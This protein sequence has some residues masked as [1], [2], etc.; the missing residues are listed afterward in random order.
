MNPRL[1]LTGVAVGAL[2]LTGCATD[3]GGGSGGGSDSLSLGYFMPETGPSASYGPPMIAAVK[4]A[5]DEI[6]ADGGVLG[7]DVEVTGG[8]TAG[9][10]T[11][12]S[13]TIDRL[14]SENV[15]A[16]FGS[17]S[18]SITLA[19]LDKLASSGTMMCSGSDSATELATYPDDGLYFRTYPAATLLV[20]GVADWMI[21]DGATDIALVGRSDAI[22]K[23][24]VGGL[25]AALEEQGVEPVLVEDYDPTAT[26][27][28]SVV[29]KIKSAEPDAVFLQT[30][31]E[32]GPLI[33]S[34]IENDLGPKDVALYGTSGIAFDDFWKSVDPNDPGVLEGLQGITAPL[35]IAPEFIDRLKK[36][37]PSLR[38]SDF[39]ATTYDCVILTALAAI[40]ADS[41]DPADLK[42]EMVGLTNGDTECTTF[43]ECADLLGDGKSITY[44]GASGAV[45][46][47]DQGEPTIGRN[48]L[49]RM[50]DK[51]QLEQVGSLTCGEDGVGS[52]TVDEG[53]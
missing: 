46:L 52:C 22:G 2:L 19:V 47:D 11:I 1:A 3:S 39:A 42:E 48:S 43:K 10:A 35:D 21:Q 27:F 34:M 9:D 38:G 41:T 5:V 31:A 49:W 37:D 23:D 29:A 40:A 50:G 8:D 51:S 13:Q 12:A 53:S 17:G 15:S 24:I 32:G 14:L 4:M 30:F 7:S 6:N 20:P 28:D 44:V 26:N 25:E 33:K 16:V 36:Q 18:S 45:G